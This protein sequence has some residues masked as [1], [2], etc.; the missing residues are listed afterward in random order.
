[1][2]ARKSESLRDRLEALFAVTK[3]LVI[4]QSL[5][6]TWLSP[7]AKEVGGNANFYSIFMS[8]SLHSLKPGVYD[9]VPWCICI[10]ACDV[11]P[12][13]IFCRDNQNDL[14]RAAFS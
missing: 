10:N 2:L 8:K 3:A 14:L 11:G 9:P 7:I 1:M 12:C 13:K 6:D 4:G 5:S